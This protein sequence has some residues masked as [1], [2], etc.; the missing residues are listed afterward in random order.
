MVAAASI[1]VAWRN[2]GTGRP[3]SAGSFARGWEN[4]RA[5]S[6][7]FAFVGMGD[8]DGDGRKD[9]WFENLGVF[10]SGSTNGQLALV[11]RL[12]SS[13]SAGA[14]D[15]DVDG[16]PDLFNYSVGQVPPH[17]QPQL[18]INRNI[19]TPANPRFSAKVTNNVPN[20]EFRDLADLDGDGRGDFLFIA[21]HESVRSVPKSLPSGVGGPVRTRTFPGSGLADAHEGCEGNLILQRPRVCGS[22]RR[23]LARSPADER[24]RRSHRD[25]PEPQP[26]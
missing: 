11:N 24:E 3:I 19:S 5:P 16:L 22:R 7:S 26:G 10:L 18:I 4:A 6:S 23:R 13:F 15:I 9:V 8:V 14:V 17:S 1:R 20:E 21:F 12:V 25:P 2:T